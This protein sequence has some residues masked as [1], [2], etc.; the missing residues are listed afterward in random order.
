[1]LR[2]AF[3]LGG[4]GSG[5][6]FDEVDLIDKASKVLSGAPQVLLEEYLTG[7]KEFE[8]EIVRDLKGNSL[9]ICNMENLDPMGIHTGESIV[10]APAQTLNDEE[11]QNLRNISFA[12]R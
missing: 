11:H 12:L 10:I 7:W 2:A 3:S 9:T 1:M 5:K 4:L 8:Y 6:V